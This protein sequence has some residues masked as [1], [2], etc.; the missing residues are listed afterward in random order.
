MSVFGQTKI[1]QL[2]R[3]FTT[4]L[5]LPDSLFGSQLTNIIVGQPKRARDWEKLCKESEHCSLKKVLT[6]ANGAVTG[7]SSFHAARG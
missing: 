2:E 1:S 6:M 4:I 7:R 5:V 3:L